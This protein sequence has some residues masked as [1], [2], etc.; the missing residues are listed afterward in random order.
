[1]REHYLEL[2]KVI[3]PAGSASGKHKA[4]KQFFFVLIDSVV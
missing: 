3:Y 4:T 1:M 2:S